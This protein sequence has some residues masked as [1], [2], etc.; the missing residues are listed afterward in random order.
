MALTRY[1]MGGSSQQSDRPSAGRWVNEIE[2]GDAIATYCPADGSVVPVAVGDRLYYGNTGLWLTAHLVGATMVWAGG[3]FHVS[4]DGSLISWSASANIYYTV[5]AIEGAAK[6]WVKSHSFNGDLPAAGPHDVSNHYTWLLTVYANST[7]VLGT[8]NGQST[9]T[10]QYNVDVNQ[11]FA[12]P[13]D[14]VDPGSRAQQMRLEWTKV[15]NPDNCN[16]VLGTIRCAFV[17]E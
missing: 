3:E 1:R 17:W 6:L 16:I 7:G 11:L 4:P 12:V 10:R 13:Q 15:L 8:T 5:P 2:S 14:G 9:V